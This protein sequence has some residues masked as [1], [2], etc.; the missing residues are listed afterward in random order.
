VT[1]TPIR[2]LS[3]EEPVDITT[4]RE[5]S[6]SGW[7]EDRCALSTRGETFLRIFRAR[8]VFA[9]GFEIDSNGRIRDLAENELYGFI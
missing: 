2:A 3:G 9:E 1:A 8:Q 4:Y 5:Y 6:S 7:A